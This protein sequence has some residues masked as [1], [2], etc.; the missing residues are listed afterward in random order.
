VTSYG[1]LK[2][3]VDV[4]SDIELGPGPIIFTNQIKIGKDLTFTCPTRDCVLDADS[5]S[6]I[7]NIK[8]GTISFDGITFKKGQAKVSPQ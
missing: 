3:A 8:G 1:E 4:C 7:F 2:R 6:Q 5:N